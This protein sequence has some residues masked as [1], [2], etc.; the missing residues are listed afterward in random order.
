MPEIAAWIVEEECRKARLGAWRKSAGI[1]GLEHGGRVPESEAWSVK[2]ECRKAR[3]GVW[4][5]CAGKRG[6]G[7][8]GRVPER[9]AR[10]V[11]EVCQKC[12]E[13]VLGSDAWSVKAENKKERLVVRRT[14][15]GKQGL[16]RGGRLP[17]SMSLSFSQLV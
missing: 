17:E 6:L 16:E 15:A 8:E 5:K 9:E 2:E 1:R 7:R 12:A 11:E 10:G 3:V 13:R 4:R 14:G